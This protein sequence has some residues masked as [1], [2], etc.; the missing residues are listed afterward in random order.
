VAP[1]H[2]LR[3][4]RQVLQQHGAQGVDLGDRRRERE[5]PVRPVRVAPVEKGQRR[6]PRRVR[7][8][9]DVPPGVVADVQQREAGGAAECLLRSGDSD[10]GQALEIGRHPGEARNGVYDQQRPASCCYPGDSVE[11]VH[12]PRRRLAVHHGDDRDVR[13]TGEDVACRCRHYRGVVVSLDLD[14]LAGEPR[15]EPPEGLAV[16]AGHQV[17]HDVIGPDHGGRGRLDAHHR[18]AGE[19]DRVNRGAERLPQQR[20]RLR[21]QRAEGRIGVVQH[22]LG[23]RRQRGRGAADRTGRQGEHRPRIDSAHVP[24]TPRSS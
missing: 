11:V 15:R 9:R 1:L 20:D 14:D 13:S 6:S 17:Q 4:F 19:D 5:R 7:V 8:G 10:A 23:E 22:R 16:D 21:V 18:L 12:R 3:P 2:V 24:L